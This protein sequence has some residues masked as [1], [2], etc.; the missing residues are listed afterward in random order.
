MDSLAADMEC[1]PDPQE[2]LAALVRWGQNAPE[3]PAALHDDSLRVAGCISRVWLDARHADGVIHLRLAADSPMV[4][5]LGRGDRAPGRR[6]TGRSARR[7][8]PRL[9]APARPGP[10]NHPD[11]A[12]WT[13]RRGQ[14]RQATCRNAVI[15]MWLDAH[16][17]L[18]DPRLPATG[19]A[20]IAALRD[21]GVEMAVVN[22]TSPADW[23]AVA[24]LA[25]RF[26]DFIRPA[27]GLHPW[28]VA[29]APAGWLADLERL[30]EDNPK[31]S[32]GEIGL[33]Q[34]IPNPD[35]DAQRAA[36]RSQ[37]ELAAALDRAVS[38]HCLKAWDVLFPLIKELAPRPGRVLIHGFTGPPEL[39]RS[40][41]RHG[42]LLGFG[43]H[44]LTPR[45]SAAR[46]AFRQIPLEH[47][48]LETDAPDM[49]A[50]ENLRT[51]FLPDRALNHPANLAAHGQALAALRGITPPTLA[52]ALRTNTLRWLD[53][54]G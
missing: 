41:V 25:A 40:L 19:A 28:K 22:G 38:V 27:F 2:R 4:R 12:P 46:E 20:A 29:T 45:K 42:F 13:R 53:P 17:H 24:T 44:A 14:P 18:H 32:V 51:H 8:R 16:N 54:G 6:P 9:A 26:P 43:G 39:A 1:V 34:W 48:L 33:D 5:G 30:L 23:P 49:P 50:P 35:I 37:W 3:L 47:I 21:S 15:S 7:R 10:A 52:A 36:F 11:Q 31:A